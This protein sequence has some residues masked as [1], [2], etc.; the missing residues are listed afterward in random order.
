MKISRPGALTTAAVLL[1]L[2]S[3]LSLATALFAGPPVPV[4]VFAVVAGLIGLVAAYELWNAKRWGM[5]V[6][7]I[8]SALNV[9]GAAPG[10]VVQPNPPAT[11]GAGVTVALAVLIIVLTVLPST[12]QAYA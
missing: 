4:K 5:I 12:R 10:L 7:I 3:L 6:A 11:I 1:G 9:L 8:V 2:V